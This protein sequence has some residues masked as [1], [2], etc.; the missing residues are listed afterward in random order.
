MTSDNT[1]YELDPRLNA[2]RP[3]LADIRLRDKVK[4]ERYVDGKP[5]QMQHPLA[6]MKAA[7]QAGTSTLNEL[8]FGETVCVFDV[9]DGWAWCQLDRDNYVGYVPIPALSETITETTHRVSSWGTFVYRQ[10]DIKS[11]PVMHIG[12]NALITVSENDRKMSALAGGGYVVNRH[13]SIKTKFARDFVALAE[14]AIGTPYLWG[15]RSRI[16]IDCSGLVQLAMQAAGLQCP[17]DSDMQC[18]MIGE[19][20]L[21]PDDLTGL[22][23]GDLVFWPGHVGIMADG[24]MLVHANAHHM[25]VVTEPLATAAARIEKTGDK[26]T[27]VKRP[28][29]LCA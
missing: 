14:R 6:P 16:G 22:E 25:A 18:E 4:A 2:F 9:T 29:K 28:T 5:Y 7:P 13:I 26:I 24:V 12:L 8:L 15:G 11:E 10:A 19:D 20:V 1:S 3:D 23:R 17:R 27:R 21:I